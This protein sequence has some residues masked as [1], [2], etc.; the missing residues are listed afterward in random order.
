M[1]DDTL[2]RKIPEPVTLPPAA[3]VCPRCGRPLGYLPFGGAWGCTS[4]ACRIKQVAERK[5]QE[6]AQ[7]ADANDS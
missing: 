6:A 5:A 4:A 7:E 1:N 2:T 3:Q